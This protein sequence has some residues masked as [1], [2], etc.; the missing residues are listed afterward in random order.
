MKVKAIRLFS[1]PVFGNV[2]E[3]DIIEVNEFTAQQLSDLGLVKLELPVVEVE[4]P[5]VEVKKAIKK[6]VKK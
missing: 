5:K 2:T 6:A 1:S 4:S 3:G